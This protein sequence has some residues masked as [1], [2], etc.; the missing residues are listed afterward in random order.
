M[1]NRQVE[2]AIA[3]V[4]E[5]VATLVNN[6]KQEQTK[7][8]ANQAKASAEAAVLSGNADAREQAGRDLVEYRDGLSGE[9]RAVYDRAVK[10]LGHEPYSRED[11]IFICDEVGGG[12][13]KRKFDEQWDKGQVDMNNLT[14]QQQWVIDNYYNGSSP[15]KVP[16]RTQKEIADK[17]GTGAKGNVRMIFPN[18]A[19]VEGE[20]YQTPAYYH[21]D[22]FLNS[23][24][25]FKKAVN[26]LGEPYKYDKYDPPSGAVPII[27]EVDYSDE[28]GTTTMST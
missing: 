17:Y 12:S 6:G 10:K 20:I 9:D 4:A 7:Q 24:S 21:F 8:K 19:V 15:T 27:F 2:R 18:V 14:E 26:D 5:G 23:K 25:A 16:M 28:E 13:L 3:W 11:Y 22:V 1:R